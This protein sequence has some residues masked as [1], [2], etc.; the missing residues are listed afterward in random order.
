[1]KKF[2]LC[3]L[4]IIIVSLVASCG[5]SGMENN[6]LGENKNIVEK[7]KEEKETTR[8]VEGV[9]E[10]NKEA[11]KE[12]ENQYIIPENLGNENTATPVAL[13]IL[14]LKVI[15]KKG[16]VT[17]NGLNVRNLG[18]MKGKVLT[19]INKGV[20]VHIFGEKDNWYYVEYAKDKKGWV[21]SRYI[22]FEKIK[23]SPIDTSLLSNKSYNWY[24]VRNNKHQQPGFDK[25]YKS[26]LDKYQGIAIG[27]KNKK[28]IFLTF[29]NGY[30]N[31]YTN[32]ILDILKRQ[33]IKVGFFVQGT[34]IDKNPEIVRRMVKEGHIVLN[35][36]NNH[37]QMPTL[38][39]EKLR[40]EINIVE[41]KYKKVTGKDMLKFIRPPSGTF[42]ERTLAESKN[43][44]YRSVFWSMAYRDWV[45]D[46]Q[47]GKQASY[48]HVTDN[49]HNGAVILLHS[50]SKSNTEALED[51][52]KELKRQG[53]N[54]KLLTQY[55]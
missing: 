11:E 30:E 28:D 17:V 18:S 1:M 3:I 13:Q 19:S 20:E 6:D 45:V 26:M 4:F 55:P 43:L 33:N 7:P 34:Y 49:I 47:P 2:S 12:E 42:S 48:K 23:S 52:I 16:Y 51:I 8:E 41:E 5:I 27:N 14:V 36:T 46:D 38:S 9:V 37:P 53:Y 31:G 24:F 32:K 54:F 50:V 25:T 39:K 10:E 40:Y 15:E 29:D 35:H 44:G 21:Y 22:Q